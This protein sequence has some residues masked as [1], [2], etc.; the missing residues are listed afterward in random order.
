M[1]ILAIIAFLFIIDALWCSVK[2]RKSIHPSR[3]CPGT[4]GGG[5]AASKQGS[6]NTIKI[7]ITTRL[8]DLTFLLFKI[9][10]YIPSHLIRMFF[11]RF[12]F[13][14]TIGKHVVI[15]YGLESRCPWNIYIG[16]GTIIGDKAI[17]DARYGIEF[18]ENVNLSTGVQIWT[19]QH[20]VNSPTFSSTGTEAGIIIDDRAWISSR[21]T[22]LP[23]SHIAEGAVIAS[24]A[25]VTKPVE[26]PFTIWGGI[27]A[28]KI[29]ERNRG[30]T[31]Q[32]DGSHR[33]FL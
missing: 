18:G 6:S 27:P 19:L 2:K 11:Y 1:I 14:M 21:T 23:G 16:N 30:L 10:G 13:R 4:H 29:G 24:G 5:T 26:D 25:V 7:F 32:F 9:V 22:L 15:H 31:Y 28:K 33:W 20:D 3:M 12:I 17:L 8:N